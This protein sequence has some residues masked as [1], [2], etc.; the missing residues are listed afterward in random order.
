MTAGRPKRH[1][2]SF[3]RVL[4][5]V[6]GTVILFALL[7]TGIYTV[8]SPQIFASNKIS[9]LI[10]KGQIIAG[11]IESTLRGELSSTYLVP[12]IGRSTSQ[13]E[14]TVWVV[15]ASGDTLIRTQQIERRHRCSSRRRRR[16]WDRGSG[17]SSRRTG[18]QGRE[19]A[20]RAHSRG[21][22]P[23]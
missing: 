19:A 9:D 15:D 4:V 13:W 7:I 3:R 2:A 21:R 5:L 6:Y 18:A 14:A 11:Y 8:V 10:P 17:R 16:A 20:D 23:C 1:S 22:W 12:L